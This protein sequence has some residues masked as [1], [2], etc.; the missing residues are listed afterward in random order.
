MQS[1]HHKLDV[2]I[3]QILR[4]NCLETE[5]PFC[6][7]SPQ[8]DSAL[9]LDAGFTLRPLQPHYFFS[10]RRPCSKHHPTSYKTGIQYRRYCAILC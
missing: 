5:Y 10:L 3:V 9:Y 1:L 7:D 8:Q 4:Y 6:K 2:V